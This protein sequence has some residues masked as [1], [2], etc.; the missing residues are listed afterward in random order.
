MVV[1]VSLLYPLIL[2]PAVLEPDLDLGLGK[3]QGFGQLAS[4]P[5]ANILG[6][7]VLYLQAEG[8]L[9]AEGGPLP[10]RSALFATPPRHWKR[11]NC[12][13]SAIS[14]F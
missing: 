14:Q 4:P 1:Y 12:N 10:A 13:T 11:N 9:A 5:T 2:C 3:P 7:L 6:P 8:L